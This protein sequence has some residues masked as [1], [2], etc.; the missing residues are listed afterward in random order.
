MRRPTSASGTS[1]QLAISAVVSMLEY[2]G[3]SARRDETVVHDPQAEFGRVKFP[4]RSEPA[5]LSSTIRYAVADSWPRAT[6]NPI[7]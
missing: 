1:R 6:C 3:T 7:G 5:D 4:H 2:K